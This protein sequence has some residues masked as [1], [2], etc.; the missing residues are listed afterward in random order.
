MMFMD[1]IYLFEFIKRTWKELCNKYYNKYNYFSY[2][3]YIY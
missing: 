1:D 2:K 3:H